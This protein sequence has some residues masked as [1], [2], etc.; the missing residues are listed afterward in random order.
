MKKFVFYYESEGK[1]VFHEAWKQIY[2]GNSNYKDVI[3][4]FYS[5]AEAGT[6]RQ[7]QSLLWFVSAGSGLHKNTGDSMESRGCG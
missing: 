4:L 3:R 6:H 1:S 7:L 2:F 5:A